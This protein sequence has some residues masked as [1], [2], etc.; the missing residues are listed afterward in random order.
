MSGIPLL[1]SSI[2]FITGYDFFELIL[3]AR[4]LAGLAHGIVYITTIT[5]LAENLVKEIRGRV[6]ALVNYMLITAIFL[7]AAI[8][9]TVTEDNLEKADMYFGVAGAIASTLGLIF[10]QLLTKESVTLLLR[11]DKDRDVLRIMMSLRDETVETEQIRIEMAELKLMITEEANEG[12]NI[13]FNGNLRPLLL[14]TI[15]K[16]LGV[17]TNNM[18]LNGLMISMTQLTTTEDI[19]HMGILTLSRFLLAI[20]S[21]LAFDSFPRKK[22]LSITGASMV[23]V[24]LI[25][26]VISLG[27]MFEINGIWMPIVFFVAFQVIV[28]LGIDPMQHV[29]TA[30]AFNSTPK[31]YWSIAF[32]TTVEHL[33]QIAA[34]LV[35]QAAGMINV[36]MVM[37][38]TAFVSLLLHCVLEFF[39]PETNGYSIRQ[40]RINFK[41]PIAFEL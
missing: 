31:A 26:S 29:L 8:Y 32:A 30:E 2:L 11:Q 34:I 7:A 19:T 25:Y 15:T 28:S 9:G 12:L 10:T 16:V 22:I 5:H 24:L 3:C 6:L 33:L 23:I 20:F 40:T 13:F 17:F 37:F 1:I 21:L 14:I 38:P 27:Y 41:N 36:N 39:V 4:L 18:I 35:Y